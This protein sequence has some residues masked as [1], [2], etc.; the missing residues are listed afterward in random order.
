MAAA[1]G[2]DLS[3]FQAEDIYRM[4]IT[5]EQG[6][7]DFYNKI[8]DA[9]DNQRVKNEMRFLRDEEGRH[10]AFFLKQ[11]TDKGAAADK[12][13]DPGLQKLLDSEFLTPLEDLY[14]GKKVGNNAEALR[15]GMDIEQKTVDFYSA[16]KDRQTDAAFGKDLDVIIDEERKH[17]QK[18]NIILA[19]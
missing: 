1:K 6:G 7:F 10:K 3:K 14:K 16:L 19:Y 15:F 12:K 8:I 4:A 13:I 2:W 5:I 11:L 18:L 17:K 9:S